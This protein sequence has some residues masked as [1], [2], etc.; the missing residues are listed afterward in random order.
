MRR[1][2]SWRLL[3]RGLAALDDSLTAYLPTLGPG[4]AVVSM[5]SYARPVI[6]Q[7]DPGGCKLLLAD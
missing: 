2:N 7:V 3:R 1:T 4:A 6:V 5:G